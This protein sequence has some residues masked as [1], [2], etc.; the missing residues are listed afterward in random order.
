MTTK[1][2]APSPNADGGFLPMLWRG[3]RGPVGAEERAEY[4]E[5]QRR[6]HEKFPEYVAG[7]RRPSDATVEA[8][9]AFVGD[10]ARGL[11]PVER[12]ALVVVLDAAIQA[13]QDRRL[14]THNLVFDAVAATWS[15]NYRACVEA[16]RAFVS[17]EMAPDTLRSAWRDLGREGIRPATLV[18]LAQHGCGLYATTRTREGAAAKYNVALTEATR[19]AREQ[20]LSIVAADAKNGGTYRRR[21]SKRRLLLAGSDDAVE[22][23]AAYYEPDDDEDDLSVQDFSRRK[24]V[25]EVPYNVATPRPR[26]LEVIRLLE[27]ARLYLDV[28]ALEAEY[29]R[30]TDEADAVYGEALG[31]YGVKLTES[32]VGRWRRR[33]GE[34]REGYYRRAWQSHLR[35]VF[36]R[37]PDDETLEAVIAFA[38]TF[39]KCVGRASQLAVVR[40]QAREAVNAGRAD[41]HGELLIRTRYAKTWN[42]RF[43]AL[44]FWATEVSGKQPITEMTTVNLGPA[45]Y[46][47]GP[48]DAPEPD[49]EEEV[50]STTVQRGRLFRVAAFE[51]AE[52]REN[53]RKRRE[54]YEAG[55]NLDDPLLEDRQHLVGVDVSGSQIQIYA[56]LL[57][58]N[59]LAAKLKTMPYKQVATLRARERHADPADA[60]KLPARLTNPQLVAAVKAATM[61]FM[62]DS[63][64]QKIAERFAADPT[65]YGDGLGSARNLTLFLRDEE[66]QLDVIATK[67]KPACRR[68]AR[69]AYAADPHAGVSFTDPYD[70]ATVRWNPIAWTLDPRHARVAGSGDVRIYAKTPL[71]A[72]NTAGD[73]PVSLNEL[74]RSFG[75][76]FIH[77]LD[78]MFCGLVVAE[79]A[80]FGVRDFVAIHDA[81]LVPADAEREL[82]AAVEAAG[83]PWYER[84]GSIY[85]DLERLLGTC[86]PPTRGP[87]KGQCCGHCANWI[88]GLRVR[89]QQR[90]AAGD[91]WPVF[92]VG[93]AEHLTS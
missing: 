41:A 76:C 27:G 51:S 50:T 25:A 21:S 16:G 48:Y 73:Y 38:R 62:Y 39:D 2:T 26:S 32:P 75:P 30:L 12:Q 13:G 86:T 22:V 83:R 63:P 69:R 92:R 17:Y 19:T 46:P 33:D 44:D 74:V 37:C 1:S 90:V 55:F 34:S 82:L 3:G 7:W 4:R 8:I 79:L 10:A 85:D 88:R 70:G 47:S 91:D 93:E 56:F 61:E 57:G 35:K 87:R 60:F 20:F 42:R 31:V 24:I 14:L 68:I 64:P 23:P 58:L 66:L 11:S 81:W 72:K 67:W 29:G 80:R 53:E 77:T 49:I 6:H 40:D 15:D 36:G 45:G 78:A 9:C 89:W 54:Y 52:E 71:G 43:Q 59:R 65:E 18:K 5:R 84:L 28:K